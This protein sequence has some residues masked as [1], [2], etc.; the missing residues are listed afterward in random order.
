MLTTRRAAIFAGSAALAFGAGAA[1]AAREPIWTDVWGRALGG[2]DCLS[3]HA[4]GAPIL[5]DRANEI[6]W[7]GARWLFASMDALQVFIAAP[8]LYA[9]AY[10]GHCAATLAGEGRLI[11]PDPGV[12]DLTAD[13]LVLLSSAAKHGAWRADPIGGLAAADAAW[14]RLLEG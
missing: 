14:T 7:S 10:G 8:R 2:Y 12:F 6:H 13:R 11:A 5:G 4:D 9:P 1:Q 3:Y